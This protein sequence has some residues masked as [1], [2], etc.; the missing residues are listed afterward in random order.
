MTA[1][2]MIIGMVPMAL[3]MGEGGEQNAPLGRAVI[4]GLLF[5]TVATLIFVPAV[6][7]LLHGGRRTAAAEAR[8]MSSPGSRRPGGQNAPP[9]LLSALAWIAIALAALRAWP[10][11]S[12][13]TVATGIARAGPRRH[14][15]A[16]SRP[17]SMAVPTVT[18]IH[19][20]R[21]A[22]A[23]EV[24]LPGNAQAYV[25]TPIYARTN[26]YLKI[27]VFRYR[28][29]REIRPA[30]G[31]NRDSRSRSPARPGARRSG[32][33][34]GQLRTLPHHRRPLPVAVQE[35][36][37]GQAGCGRPR[38]RS[39][40]PRRPWSI[41][42]PSTCAAWKRRQHFQKVYAPF[43]GVITARNIDIGAL[44]NAGSNAPARSCSISPPPA[45]CACTSMCRRHT[46]AT[47]AL[48]RPA[49]LTLAEFPGRRF[50]G[51]IVRSSDSIDPASRTLLTEVDVDNSSGELLPGAF[52]SV[53]LKLSSQR[54]RRDRSR[55]RSDFPRRRA[56]R[57]AWCGATRRSWCRI[58]IGRDYG[59]EVE[60][61]SRHHARR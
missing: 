51:T 36:F 41:P 56:C 38:R 18:V 54:R 34:A 29:A 16:S 47:C 49:D 40:R 31:G 22:P 1:L 28:R 55:Q 9:R 32:H 37:G 25:A 59:T 30:A 33:R 10:A 45:S 60:V 11:P 20:R 7:A 27:L 52:F 6:F 44:I 23:E 48:A 4:G 15:A 58:T 26:G 53:H 50:T 12:P 21:G 3:G 35:R 19:P 57:S 2:A 13:T 5:A 43:D 39:A 24:V 8:R 46:R 42:L 14:H 17:S 61:L